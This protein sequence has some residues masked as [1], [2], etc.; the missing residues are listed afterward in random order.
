M[1]QGIIISVDVVL[2]TLSEDQLQVVV[3]RRDRDPYRQQLALPGGYIHAEEDGDSLAAAGRVLK[4]K[5]GLVSPYLEQLYTFSGGA[6]DP[7]G[8]SV[9]IAYFALVSRETLSAQGNA[10]FQL[11]PVDALPHLPFDHNR[12]VEFASQR[13]RS[14]STYSAL[15]CYLLPQDF[16]LTELQQTY[17]KILGHR[18]DKSTFRRKLAEQDF[19]EPVA[20]AARTGTHR[21]AQLYRA[22]PGSGLTLFDRTI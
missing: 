18:L 21:P 4:E 20:G 11:L 5:T 10:N 1:E 9:S 12:I 14:K 8:W 15:P 17:E 13:L 22:R 16:T 3:V 6:R 19:L 2:F 7:R